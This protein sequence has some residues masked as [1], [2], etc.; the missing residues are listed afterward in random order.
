MID[1][2]LNEFT[3]FLSRQYGGRWDI[4]MIVPKGRILPL[5]ID[6]EKRHRLYDQIIDD[7]MK[8]DYMIIH[9]QF[10]SVTITEQI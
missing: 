1:E 9:T 2:A 6:M 8:C 10:G 3:C 4:K 7:K 5:M